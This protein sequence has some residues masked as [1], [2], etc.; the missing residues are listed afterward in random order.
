MLHHNCPYGG[1]CWWGCLGL[2]V[3][4]YVVAS[5]F[6]YY[7]WNHVIVEH[8]KT[9]KAKWWQPFLLIATI[10]VLLAPCSMRHRGWGG[11]HCAMGGDCPMHHQGMMGDGDCPYAKGDGGAATAAPADPNAPKSDA[12]AV[13]PA[14]GTDAAAPAAPVRRHRRRHAAAPA[15]T[16]PPPPAK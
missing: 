8:F 12:P 16:T 14:T 6:L 15:P 2:A 5:G 13:A 3:L 10:C 9:K 11:S 4:W 7:C 1:S